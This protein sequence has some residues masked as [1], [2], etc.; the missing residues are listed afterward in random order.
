MA[1]SNASG[2]TEDTLCIL[3]LSKNHIE[4]YITLLTVPLDYFMCKSAV[5][6]CQFFNASLKEKALTKMVKIAI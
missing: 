1:V 5:T 3:T 2:G 6:F 4:R